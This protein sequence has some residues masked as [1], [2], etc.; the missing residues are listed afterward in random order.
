MDRKIGTGSSCEVFKG[1]WRGAEV[2]IKKMKIKS[3][4]ENHLKEFGREISALVSIKTHQN[5]V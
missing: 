2:A 4:S 3:L 1:Y 5:L